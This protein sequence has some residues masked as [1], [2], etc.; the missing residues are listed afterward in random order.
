MKTVAILFTLLFVA[1]GIVRTVNYYS[2]DLGVTQH[3][4][5]AADANTTSIAK[6][7]LSIAISEIERRG[8][9]SGIVS[10]VLHQ[11]SNDIGFWYNNIKTSYNELL[12]L[13]DTSTP[14][15]KS[16]MLMKLRETLLDNSKNG[17]AVTCPSGISIYPYNALY[18]WWG[19]ASLL[20]ACFFWLGAV[21]KNY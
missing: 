3:L 14:L 13:P 11:P 12:V 6:S 5:R 2:F 18:F 4:K 8:L 16:N 19:L 7:E 17:T 21:A 20:L 1:W 15:E 9:T 10:L